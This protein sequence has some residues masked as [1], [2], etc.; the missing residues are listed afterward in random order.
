M[1][2]AQRLL[3]THVSS[4]ARILLAPAH[5]LGFAPVRS[6]H[7]DTNARGRVVRAADVLI[8]SIAPL[9]AA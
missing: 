3:V 4:N 8:A 6:N 7:I 1:P 5:S 2:F 9:L